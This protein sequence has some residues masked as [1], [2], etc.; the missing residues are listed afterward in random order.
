MSN[1]LIIAGWVLAGYFGYTEADWYLV[2][3][4][5]SMAVIGYMVARSGQMY[6]IVNNDGFVGFAKMILFQ[7]IGWSITTFAIYFIARMFS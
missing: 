3:I 5:S 6:G 1:I 2:F 7:M 4:S